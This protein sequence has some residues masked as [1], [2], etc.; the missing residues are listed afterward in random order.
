MR[1]SEAPSSSSKVA[2][3][4]A[5]N[6][7]SIIVPELLPDEWVLGIV[8][9]FRAINGIPAGPA[10]YR[11]FDQAVRERQA[12]PATEC[13]A[14]MLGVLGGKS[15]PDIKRLHSTVRFSRLILDYDSEDRDFEYRK[16]VMPRH[17]LSA[18]CETC[19]ISDRKAHGFSFWRISHQIPGIQHCRICGT[20]L[21]FTEADPTT[22]MPADLDRSQCAAKNLGRCTGEI[23]C[24]YEAL[25]H[26]ILNDFVPATLTVVAQRLRQ[27]AMDFGYRVGSL[28]KW[29]NLP[30]VAT[31]CVEPMSLFHGLSDSHLHKVIDG[32]SKSPFCYL[33]L[34]LGLS[35][36]LEGAQAYF[37]RSPDR[38]QSHQHY[39]SARLDQADRLERHVGI[40]GGSFSEY[41]KQSGLLLSEVTDA[42]A[43]FGL[44]DF[45]EVSPQLRGAFL[46]FTDGVG[47][48]A[49]AEQVGIDPCE[50]ESLL[51]VTSE[52]SW[53]LASHIESVSL[54]A[55]SAQSTSGETSNAA[56]LDSMMVHPKDRSMA[57]A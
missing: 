40:C 19:V 42:C 30:D 14:V 36:N 43:R 41:A 21:L 7:L 23:A 18:F 17:R 28:G 35:S 1:N 48:V 16:A 31:A 49:S 50:L 33:V 10:V 39:L 45:T 37:S 51:R 13:M 38:A 5:M 6:T 9:R 34:A 57:S 15:V 47:L 24:R 44:P 56:Q 54:N 20:D 4:A 25:V 32:D 8:S 22:V 27:A 46:L 3:E 26:G 55:I 11:W 52:P 2:F 12:A 29:R 53:R